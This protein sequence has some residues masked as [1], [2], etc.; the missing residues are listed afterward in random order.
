MDIIKIPRKKQTTNTAKEN[1][2]C[3]FKLKRQVVIKQVTVSDI[4][5]N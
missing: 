5:L 4:I 2:T 3:K 1:D